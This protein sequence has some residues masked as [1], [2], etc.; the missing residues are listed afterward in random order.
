MAC[1][2]NFKCADLVSESLQGLLSQFEVSSRCQHYHTE[3]EE[4]HIHR[5]KD[6]EN[7]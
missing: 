4:T 3:A 6:F 1:I 5:K 2:H 7:V